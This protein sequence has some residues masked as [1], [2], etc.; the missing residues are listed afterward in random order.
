[1]VERNQ[2]DL[3]NV[4]PATFSI[5]ASN[6]VLGECVLTVAYLINRTPSSL[7]GNK[8]PFELLHKKVVGYFHLKVFGCLTF[9][10]T[11]S[12]RLTKFS[13]QNMCFPWLSNWY[14]RL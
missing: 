11:L 14:E 8:T 10:S 2:Q 6:S 7:L 13:C 12:A 1:M 5:K 3:L 9:S 4:A